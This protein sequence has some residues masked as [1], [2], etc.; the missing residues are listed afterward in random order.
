M[1]KLKFWMMAMLAI[2]ATISLSACG[3]DE[4]PSG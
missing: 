1:K 3:D 2:V 4:E